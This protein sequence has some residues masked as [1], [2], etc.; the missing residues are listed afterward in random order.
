MDQ[1]VWC[2]FLLVSI[3]LINA[4][5][6]DD[7]QPPPPDTNPPAPV[8]STPIPGEDTGDII[9]QEETTGAGRV[10]GHIKARI[11]HPLGVNATEIIQ[12]FLINVT[13]GLCMDCDI[14][15]DAT[16][17]QQQILPVD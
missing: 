17:T 11:I 14:D 3:P 2:F 8:D 10:Y 13:R 12:Q 4:Q 9:L 5:T 16:V 1:F 7:N 6:D 15:V